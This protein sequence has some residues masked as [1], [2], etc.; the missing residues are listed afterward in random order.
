MASQ[1]TWDSYTQVSGPK[2]NSCCQ[3]SNENCMK[4]FNIQTQVWP[5]TFPTPQLNLGFWIFPKA[6][7]LSLFEERMRG[8]V[9]GFVEGRGGVIEWK[10]GLVCE[11]KKIVFFF[12]TIKYKKEYD[13]CLNCR[14]Y[15]PG[16][17][18]PLKHH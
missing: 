14:F 15:T 13:F 11:M 10:L 7:C 3:I 1:E 2:M 9:G 5:N 18:C 6:M 8:K 12:K 17:I 16:I 4:V